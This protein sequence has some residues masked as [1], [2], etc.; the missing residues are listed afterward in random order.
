MRF[1]K[2][3]HNFGK[4]NK[5]FNKKKYTISINWIETEV[6]TSD[7]FDSI[8]PKN[9]VGSIGIFKNFDLFDFGYSDWFSTKLTECSPR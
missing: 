4:F 5:I 8:L 3:I 2:N 1:L 7:L 6:W 9:L